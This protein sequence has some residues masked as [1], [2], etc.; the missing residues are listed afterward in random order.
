MAI[1]HRFERP[2]RIRFS[3]CDPAGIVFYPRY[4]TMFNDL[5]EDWVSHALRIPYDELL[6]RRRVGLPTV[7]LTCRFAA[8]SLMGEDVTLGLSL[9][10]LGRSS[11]TLA[12]GCRRGEEQRVQIE[13]VLVATDLHTHRPIAIP[14]DLRQAMLEFQ[15]D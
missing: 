11:V 5:V 9:Q 12:L 1:Q 3:H 13:Q 15:Q 10:R 6:G 2:L 4:F 7:S 8:I 14:E